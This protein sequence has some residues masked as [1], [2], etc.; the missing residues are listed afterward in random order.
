MA[1][2]PVRS[3]DIDKLVDKLS[4]LELGL[5]PPERALLLFMLGVAADTIHHTRSTGHARALVTTSERQDAPVV[6]SMSER[7]PSIE[8]EFATAFVAGGG[9]RMQPLTGSVSIGPGPVDD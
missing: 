5:T 8:D 2:V 9:G 7:A 3:S 6:V 4:R 1:N